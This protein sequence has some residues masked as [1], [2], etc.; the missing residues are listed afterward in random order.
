MEH[1]D[2]VKALVVFLEWSIDN[3]IDENKRIVK[4]LAEKLHNEIKKAANEL[5][6]GSLKINIVG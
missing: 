5:G 2:N 4:A 1:E 6:K 3:P